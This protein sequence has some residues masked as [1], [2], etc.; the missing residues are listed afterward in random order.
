M[1]MHFSFDMRDLTED[2]EEFGEEV[3]TRLGQAH[4]DWDIVWTPGFIRHGDEFRGSFHIVGTV[5]AEAQAEALAQAV[6]DALNPVVQQ[7]LQ[8]R[9]QHGNH[10]PMPA[11]EFKVWFPQEQ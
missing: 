9:A 11:F 7:V 4:E 6:I 3:S 8:Q 10:T 2:Q 1:R 5:D